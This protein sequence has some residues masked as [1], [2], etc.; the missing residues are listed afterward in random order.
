[1]A[2]SMSWTESG[3][4]TSSG[5]TILGTAR[6]RP[7]QDGQDRRG[8]RGVSGFRR[9]FFGHVHLCFRSVRT[10]GAARRSGV[11]APPSF[12]RDGDFEGLIRRPFHQPDFPGSRSWKAAVTFSG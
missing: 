6:N 3:C 1:M 5:V 11:P 7:P 12:M 8:R 2:S 4:I 10:Q 9:F